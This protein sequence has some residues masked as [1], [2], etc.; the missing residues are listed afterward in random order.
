MPTFEQLLPVDLVSRSECLGEER[1]IPFPDVLTAISV[2]TA[3]EI[4][5]LGV[6]VYLISGATT[7]FKDYSEYE[8]AFG[9]DWSRFVEENNGAATEFISK[10]PLFDGFRYVLTVADQDEFQKL[11]DAEQ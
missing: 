2:A 9:G 4:A 3:N 11:E 6:E 5:V 1:A 8:V 7:S 10:N